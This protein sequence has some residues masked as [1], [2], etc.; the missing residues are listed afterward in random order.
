M[1]P[2][3]QLRKTDKVVKQTLGDTFWMKYA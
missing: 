1:N 2:Q 3:L